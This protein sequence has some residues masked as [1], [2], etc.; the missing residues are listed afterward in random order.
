MIEQIDTLILAQ[1]VTIGLCVIVQN[2]W[3]R[4]AVAAVFASTMLI[5]DWIFHAISSNLFLYYTSA[6]LVDL[7]VIMTITRLK[8]IPRLGVDVQIIAIVSMAYNFLGLILHWSGYSPIMYTS[9][10]AVLYS[11]AIFVLLRGEPEDAR[12]YSMGSWI[13]AFRFNAHPGHTINHHSQK[14][15]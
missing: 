4:R 8:R 9:L 15:Q 3:E 6:G 13:S 7:T 2:S 10:Y 11:W 14:A 1:M 12:D 5:H